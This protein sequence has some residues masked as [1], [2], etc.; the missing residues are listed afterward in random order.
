MKNISLILN[1]ILLAAVG[2]LYYLNLRKAKPVE[3]PMIMPAATNAGVRVAHVNADNLDA[4]YGWLKKQKAA[5][6]QKV[7]SAQNS[8]GNKKEALM[9]DLDAFQGKYQSGTMTEADAKAQYEKLM[10][11]QQKLGEEEERLSKQLGEDQ[12]KAFNDLY[13]NV[14][15]QLKTLSSQIGYDYILS[16]SRG[17]PILLANDSLDITT[18][19]LKLLNAQEVGK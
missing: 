11:R 13:A 15:S 19:V 2:H 4:N 9:K 18:E 8:L 5:I 14:E 1:V 17:G 6:E 7:S 12:K 10:Q 3:Q 16:Y